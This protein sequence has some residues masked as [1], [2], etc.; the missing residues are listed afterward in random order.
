M[1][2]VDFKKYLKDNWKSILLKELAIYIPSMLF[3]FGYVW[4][5]GLREPLAN[6]AYFGIFILYTGY[7]I[8]YSLLK[9][10]L[11]CIMKVKNN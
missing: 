2:W 1:G 5:D 9:L 7:W 10:G 4:L 6:D 3:I 8:C 11:R